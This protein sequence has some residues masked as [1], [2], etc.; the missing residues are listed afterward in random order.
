VGKAGV[1]ID[2]DDI[3][4]HRQPEDKYVLMLDNV[5]TVRGKLQHSRRFSNAT[6]GREFSR[7]LGRYTRTSLDQNFVKGVDTVHSAEMNSDGDDFGS[8]E[9]TQS[10]TWSPPP[11]DAVGQI[12][13]PARIETV[14]LSESGPRSYF[15][16]VAEHYRPEMLH[17][18]R[19]DFKEKRLGIKDRAD[20]FV[21]VEFLKAMK[22]FDT[23]TE[24][25]SLNGTRDARF[26]QFIRERFKTQPFVAPKDAGMD[27]P[28]PEHRQDVVTAR[29]GEIT[30]KQVRTMRERLST[31]GIYR[32][33]NPAQS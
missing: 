26:A 32:S 12:I 30:A 3:L 8:K 5:V 31:L 29:L 19:P 20:A 1:M 11:V 15:E 25:E 6:A 2:K 27:S 7:A 28:L 18:L 21:L 23:E 10:L 22:D 33:A 16:N 9:P 14:I 17:L 13:D 4:G 24:P